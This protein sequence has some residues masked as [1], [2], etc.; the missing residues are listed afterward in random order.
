MGHQ[1]SDWHQTVLGF[2]FLA[3]GLGANLLGVLAPQLW[4]SLSNSWLAIIV[5]VAIAL[6]AMGILLIHSAFNTISRNMWVVLSAVILVTLVPIDWYI[7]PR[8]SGACS[9]SF[10]PVIFGTFLENQQQ[11]GR[12]EVPRKIQIYVEGGKKET[13]PY[14]TALHRAFEIGNWNPEPISE[15]ANIATEGADG[16]FVDV[17]N[18]DHLAIEAYEQLWDLG[19]PLRMHSTGKVGNAWIFW[20][21]D[22]WPQ[23]ALKKK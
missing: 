5:F 22:S 14:A 18:G 1:E 20:I 12:N 9:V 23:A 17:P 11:N 4:P 13:C 10:D 2:A 19:Q 16:V 21:K 7:L 6:I 15:Q 3:V 8:P